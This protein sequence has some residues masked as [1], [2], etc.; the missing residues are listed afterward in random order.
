MICYLY[1]IGVLS[2]IGNP[3]VTQINT[4][5]LYISY[6]AP[7]TLQGVPVL[8][9]IIQI[10]GYDSINTTSLQ[11]YVHLTNHCLLYNINIAAYNAVGMGSITNIS[12]IILYKGILVIVTANISI[13]TYSS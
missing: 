13:I 8:Y 10:L 4:S 5:T 12:D 2:A 3:Q 1:T 6:T 9:Y 7:Y 11:H